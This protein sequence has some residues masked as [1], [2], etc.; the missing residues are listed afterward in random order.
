MDKEYVILVH[1]GAGDLSELAVHPEWEGLYY[2]ALETVLRIGERKM[3]ETGD[4][5]EVVR[6]VINYFENNPLFNAGIG[7]TVSAEGSFEL[8]ACIMQGK[9]LSAGAVAGL[10]HVKHP[11][12]AAN[13]VMN[14]S[15][16]VFLEGEGAEHFASD[17]G[18]EMVEDNMYFATPDTMK[19][20][21]EFK[22][23]SR[24]NGTVG[25]TV[26]DRQGNLVAG[27]ST[28]GIL[29]KKYGRVGDTPV[30]GAGTYADNAGTAVSCTGHG[31]Y[32]IRHN[33]AA[34]VN[35]RV[36]MMKQPVAEAVEDILF[37]E[38]NSEAGN[39]GLIAVDK[40]GNF[41]INYNSKGMFRGFLYRT[42]GVG[43]SAG[44]GIYRDM[45]PV[46]I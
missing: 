6:S 22:A 9:D 11:I 33:V 44:V 37:R 43:V 14:L 46:S 32:F 26:L 35:F 24:K 27:T 3:Q 20:V 39:G 4:G 36:K 28:G 18:L 23:M 42:P 7:A 16:H 5:V 30:I 17:N 40:D 34:S 15:E 38:L 25:C 29:G 1:G 10:R 8:D 41:T 21:D 45:R 2:S 12:E 31:E 19:W 13:A